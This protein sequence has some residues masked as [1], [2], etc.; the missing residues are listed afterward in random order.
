MWEKERKASAFI[1]TKQ[2]RHELVIMRKQMDSL[3]VL[4]DEDKKRFSLAQERLKRKIEELTRKNKEMAD[5]VSHLEKESFKMRE[6][7]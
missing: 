3:K 1:P 2:E 4:Y 5:E 7:V 6:E